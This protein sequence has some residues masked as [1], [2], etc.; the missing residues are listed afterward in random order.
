MGISFPDALWEVWFSA[1]SR[2]EAPT[3]VQRAGRTGREVVQTAEAQLSTPRDLYHAGCVTLEWDEDRF[4]GPTLNDSSKLA[5]E[6]GDRV[7]VLSLDRGRGPSSWGKTN[8]SAVP[9]RAN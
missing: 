6:D 8:K 1:L 7:H 9:G 3:T 5:C 4:A 2:R